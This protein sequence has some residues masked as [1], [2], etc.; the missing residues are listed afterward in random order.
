M[1]RRGLCAVSQGMQFS[2][3]L[4]L[5]TDSWS[6]SLAQ[7]TMATVLLLLLQKWGQQGFLW[8]W[9]PQ[10]Q[11]LSWEHSAEQVHYYFS[12][13]PSLPSSF[14]FPNVCR[15]RATKPL[16]KEVSV[17]RPERERIRLGCPFP[18]FRLGTRHP[19]TNLRERRGSL[20]ILVQLRSS[21]G[22]GVL[23]C[24]PPWPKRQQLLRGTRHLW[25]VRGV[26]QQAPSS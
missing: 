13:S 6:V 20:A 14:P 15:A 21:L 4:P 2:Y 7:P 16:G 24:F 19:L 25:P 11:A 1:S 23:S 3:L 12:T 18:C 5:T 22:C 9:Q 26:L 10:H 8:W 17:G